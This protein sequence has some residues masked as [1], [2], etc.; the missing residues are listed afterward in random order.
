MI[1]MIRRTSFGMIALV[2]VLALAG[3]TTDALMLQ[4]QQTPLIRP[5]A[6]TPADVPAANRL[7]V[8]DSDGNVVTVDPDGTDRFALTIFHDEAEAI[9]WLRRPLPRR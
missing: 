5:D 1:R 2:A 7:L 4:L 3:C 9:Q 6:L 8:I